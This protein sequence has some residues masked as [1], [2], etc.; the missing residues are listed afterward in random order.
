MLRISEKIH[1]GSEYRSEPTGE[2]GTRYGSEKNH[3][4]STA[5][6]KSFLAVVRIRIRI[7]IHMYSAF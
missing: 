7:R 1:V 6:L 4:G 3:S 2:V 5:L